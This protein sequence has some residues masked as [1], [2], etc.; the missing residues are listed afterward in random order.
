M[1]TSIARH[2]IVRTGRDRAC[3]TLTAMRHL[4][5]T[6]VL[7]ITTAL[8]AIAQ[9]RERLPVIVADARGFYSGLGRDPVTAGDLLV[10][11]EEMPNRGFGGVTGVHIYPLRGRSVAF[12]VGGELIFARGRAVT[13]SEVEDFPPTIVNQRLFGL[14]GQ[15]SLNFGYRNGWSYITGGTG[16]LSFGSYVDDTPPL[17]RPPT[18]MTLNYG[19]GARW[20]AWRHIAF[21]F[22]IRFYQTRPEERTV[23]YPGRARSSLRILSAGIS[24][25]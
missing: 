8:P 18:Q 25:R 11:P 14:S 22:D 15:L 24:V 5:S 13:E 17:E 9:T 23:F 1:I 20:F 16:P 3:C 6:L 12:G 2:S 21:A 7:V 4:V 19:G 10:A